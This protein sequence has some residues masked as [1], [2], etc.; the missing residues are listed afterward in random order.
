VKARLDPAVLRIRQNKERGIEKHLLRVS[1]RYT[2]LLILP[3][4]AFIPFEAND[5]REISHPS[6]LQ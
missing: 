3:S 1:H 6:I 2:V 4:I 5:I